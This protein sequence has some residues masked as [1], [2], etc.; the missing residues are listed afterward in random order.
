MI[1]GP[2]YWVHCDGLEGPSAKDIERVGAYYSGRS[3]I[4]GR[5]VDWTVATRGPTVTCTWRDLAF[6][7]WRHE[8]ILFWWDGALWQRLGTK[9]LYDK[10]GI[11]RITQD[12]V[13]TT[14]FNRNDYGGPPGQYAVNFEAH[15]RPFYESGEWS[16]CG[17][18]YLN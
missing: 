17:A 18:F 16:G 14:S 1:V 9:Y 4:W 7:E 2:D 6:A 15:F 8:V 13:L 12:R 5:L 11:N 10:I 3:T